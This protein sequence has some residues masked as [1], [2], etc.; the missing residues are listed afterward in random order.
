MFVGVQLMATGCLESTWVWGLQEV[1]RQPTQNSRQPAYFREC[2]CRESEAAVEV[3]RDSEWE[4]ICW[5]QIH[6]AMKDLTNVLFYRNP[7][8]EGTWAWML[9]DAHGAEP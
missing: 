2:G 6:P 7:I 9:R 1:K 8:Y 5:V 3:E 4:L